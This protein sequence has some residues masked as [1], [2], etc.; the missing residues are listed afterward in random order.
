MRWAFPVAIFAPILLMQYPTA[1]VEL[2]TS[3]WWIDAGVGAVMGL[4]ILL[5]WWGGGQR[6]ALSGAV[7]ALGVVGTVALIATQERPYW[8]GLNIAWMLAVLGALAAS[9]S[10][11]WS[12]GWANRR[13][14]VFAWLTT[15]VAVLSPLLM[16]WREGGYLVSFFGLLPGTAMGIGLLVRAQ[17]LHIAEQRVLVRERERRLM[18]AE[19]HDVIAHEVTGIVVLAQAVGPGLA[20]PQAATALNRIEESGLRALGHIRALVTTLREGDKRGAASGG[21]STAPQDLAV[22]KLG[23]LAELRSLVEEFEE[24]TSARV[25]MVGLDEAVAANRVPG[26]VAVAAHRIVS[27]A[28]TNIRRHAGTATLVTVSVATAEQSLAIEVRDDGR[29]GGLG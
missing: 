2:T 6:W 14:L 7:V 23:G 11:A 10:P 8:W 28:L 3:A 19:L 4:L 18:A 27:E 12:G 26:P 9:W 29:G 21:T 1:G 17:R 20:D 15:A 25:R 24:M 22:P 13:E 16:G 5:L